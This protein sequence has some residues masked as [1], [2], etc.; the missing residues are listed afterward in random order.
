MSKIEGKNPITINP[1]ISQTITAD[2]ETHKRK[3]GKD[4][5]GEVEI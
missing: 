1:E 2:D 3:S 4:I 5:I